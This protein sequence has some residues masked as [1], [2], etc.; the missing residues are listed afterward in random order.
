MN[1]FESIVADYIR[2]YREQ[3]E[4]EMDQFR[5]CKTLAEAISKAAS[6]LLP[7]G[8]RYSHQYRIPAIS[9]VEARYRLVGMREEI[10]A[11]ATFNQL[12]TL[13]ETAI[14][15]IYRVGELTIYDIANRLGTWLKIEPELVYLH[16]G[17]REGAVALGFSRKLK[18]LAKDDLPKEFGQL[19]PSEIEDC[20]CIYKGWLQGEISGMPKGCNL[21]TQKPSRCCGEKKAC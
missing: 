3:A 11:C 7:N 17:T 15:D 18:T 5:E 20:L 4:R 2:D 8:K 14:S 19:K 9:L 12:H 6:C 16:R 10:E 21:V 1:V 13:I